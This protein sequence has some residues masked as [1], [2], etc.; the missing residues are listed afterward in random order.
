MPET[1]ESLVR[2]YNPLSRA[3]VREPSV[4]IGAAATA[5]T[6]YNDSEEERAET[7]WIQNYSATPLK[8]AINMACSELA[9]HGILGADSGVDQ[10]NGGRFAFYPNKAGIQTISLFSTAGV[11]AGIE[12]HTRRKGINW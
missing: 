3:N 1:P 7:I 9:F 6:I 8:Y 4:A 11:R 5:V 2:Q 10:G 12:K